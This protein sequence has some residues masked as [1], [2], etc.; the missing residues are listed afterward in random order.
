MPIF[1]LGL[2]IGA[3]LGVT[4]ICLLVMGREKAG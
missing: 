1:F 3:V 4:A 2:V